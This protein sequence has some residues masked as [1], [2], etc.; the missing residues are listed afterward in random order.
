M[1]YG[2]IGASLSSD[3]KYVYSIGGHSK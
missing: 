2:R 1:N 3:N